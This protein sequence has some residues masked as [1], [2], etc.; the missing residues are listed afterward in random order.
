MSWIDKLEQ[1]VGLKPKDEPAPAPLSDE[2]MDAVVQLSSGSMD[3]VSGLRDLFPEM[4]ADPNVAAAAA[5]VEK[6]HHALM[7][8]IEQE[9]REAEMKARSSD[10]PDR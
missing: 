9:R 2:D 1:R 3:V 7:A 5:E 4:F 10:V 6:G 8:L